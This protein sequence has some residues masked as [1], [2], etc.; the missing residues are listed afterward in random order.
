M[1]LV[2]NLDV[3]PPIMLVRARSELGRLGPGMETC[4]V[5]VARGKNDKRSGKETLLPTFDP[6]DL[7][8]EI[9]DE[10]GQRNATPFDPACYARI[11]RSPGVSSAAEGA[12]PPPLPEAAAQLEAPIPVASPHAITAKPKA[13]ARGVQ[14]PKDVPRD[15]TGEAEALGRQMY[16]YY[17]ASDFP[18][19]LLYAERVLARYPDHALAQ[20]V[21]EQCRERL[22]IASRAPR[23]TDLREGVSCAPHTRLTDLRG[24]VSC[25]PHTRLTDLRE[26]LR[27]ASV[28]RLNADQLERRAAQIDPTSSLIVGFIDGVSDAAKVASLTGLSDTEALERLHALLDLGVLEVVSA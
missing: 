12:G 22:G 28:F 1:L 26:R 18:T 5:S 8:K 13:L 23:L 20:L 11:V 7:A 25:A 3:S 6:D 27:P 10:A 14:E 9:A 15:V 2:R 19:A 21:A 17:L 24:G 16:G 4:E